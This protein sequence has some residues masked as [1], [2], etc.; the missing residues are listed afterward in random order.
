[1]QQINCLESLHESN[2]KGIQWKYPGKPMMVSSPSWNEAK[3]SNP[4]RSLI[5]PY[6]WY[7]DV[8]ILRIDHGIRVTTAIKVKGM[9]YELVGAEI[10]HDGTISLM[11]LIKEGSIGSL[12]EE[13]NCVGCGM[14]VSSNWKGELHMM[15]FMNK[16][17]QF[18][19]TQ[20]SKN[21][22]KKDKRTT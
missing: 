10:T 9:R 1:M 4:S 12:S 8:S 3:D 20:I 13:G 14:A 15:V 21:D 19:I 18:S 22:L 2:P 16:D 6:W 17:N 11:W 7:E 5:P